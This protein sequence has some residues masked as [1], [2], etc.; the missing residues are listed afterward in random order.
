VKYFSYYLVFVILFSVS[1]NAQIFFLPD[2]YEWVVFFNVKKMC[3]DWG[4]EFLLTLK[5]YSKEGILFIHYF[6]EN[7]RNKFGIS[8]LDDIKYFIIFKLYNAVGIELR[9]N[10]SS[11]FYKFRL[12][13]FIVKTGYKLLLT[14]DIS[15]ILWSNTHV[16]FVPCIIQEKYIYKAKKKMLVKP[17]NLSSTYFQIR[18]KVQ[19]EFLYNKET[20]LEFGEFIF[21]DDEILLKITGKKYNSPSLTHNK[22]VVLVNKLERKIKDLRFRVYTTLKRLD[23]SISSY[24]EFK[25]LH[26]MKKSFKQLYALLKKATMKI[27][28]RQFEI[29]TKDDLKNKALLIV[30]VLL[31]CLYSEIEA[32]QKRII[33][34]ECMENMR[35]LERIV[36]KYK[37]DKG[38]PPR[39]VLQL[40]LSHYLKESIACP[41]RGEYI[42]SPDLKVRCP[43][44][45]T[46]K[47]PKVC[48][49][50]ALYRI[51]DK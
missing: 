24:E 50:K 36:L 32:L 10:L 8:I 11:L 30:G 3:E 48:D 16:T 35:R 19:P 9:G 12:E 46:L 49:L 17:F 37:R 20:I 15:L 42:I 51:F 25:R 5:G 41:L 45:G 21:S 44:H 26:K 13:D 43:F 27:R 29:K 28:G 34:D 6:L 14:D 31:K 18:F 4:E 22:L 1:C 7:F 2:D 39:N 38:Y 23:Y 33:F 40:Y 47:K